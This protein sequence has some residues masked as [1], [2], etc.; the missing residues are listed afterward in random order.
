MSTITKLRKRTGSA[1]KLVYEYHLKKV[2]DRLQN[3]IE[4]LHLRDNK[5]LKQIGD[6]AAQRT[7]REQV[8]R[9]IKNEFIKEFE[10]LEKLRRDTVK[11]LD[12][13]MSRDLI[14]REDLNKIL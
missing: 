12:Y 13:M 3:E 9:I 7:T 8:R 6:V 11:V 10:K 1:D 4:N 5:Q 2:E 14:P